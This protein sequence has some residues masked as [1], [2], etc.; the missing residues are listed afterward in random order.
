MSTEVQSN[1]NRLLFLDSIRGIA[2]L[3]V[4]YLHF[5]ERILKNEKSNTLIDFTLFNIQH[6]VDFGKIGVVVFFAISGFVIPFSL[7][8]DKQHPIRTFLISRFFRLYPVYWLSI[9]I[10]I[11]FYWYLEGKQISIATILINTTMMQQFFF[12]ENIM[13]LY[14]TL[15]IEL[16]FYV[17]CIALFKIKALNNLEV[18]YKISLAF[19]VLSFIA[20]ALRYYFTFRFPVALF[21]ALAFMFWGTVWRDYLFNKNPDSKRKGIKIVFAMLFLIPLISLLAYNKDMGFNETWY[22]YTI[23]YYLAII[24]LLLLTLKY[25]ITNPLFVWLGQISFSL[26]L[27]HGIVL[28]ALNHTIGDS[29]IYQYYLPAHLYIA[30][31][32]LLSIALAGQIYKNIEKPFINYGK[33]INYGLLNKKINIP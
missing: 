3:M 24:T 10:G 30:I 13:G 4:A 1:K 33:K 28:S 2:A 27:F 20:A 25:K 15:Q 12:H 6:Y 11:I 7:L 21:L 29:F 26:Y 32:L 22:R 5:S 14:W 16:I 17:L 18:L 9:P 19:L 31:G 23:S 8:Q